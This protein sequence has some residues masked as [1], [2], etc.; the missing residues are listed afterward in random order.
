MATLATKGSR[1]DSLYWNDRSC[2]AANYYICEKSVP[3]AE[4]LAEKW[5]CN[6]S[7]TLTLHAPPTIVTS[8]GF[9]AHYPP[10]RTCVTTLTPGRRPP[11]AAVRHLRP[12][13]APEEKNSEA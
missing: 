3:G 8:P 13:A 6:R 9:P 12:G 11:R 2:L 1:R 10:S 5:S 7:L 4:P